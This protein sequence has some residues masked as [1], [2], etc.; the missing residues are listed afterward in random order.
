MTTAKA[1]RE[2]DRS[3]STNRN[4]TTKSGCV[5]DYTIKMAPNSRI[6]LTRHAQAEHNVDLD[7]SS[8]WHIFFRRLSK[9]AHGDQYPVAD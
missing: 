7:Y 3:F 4:I 5:Q 2:I 9:A 8:M 6:I 1:T